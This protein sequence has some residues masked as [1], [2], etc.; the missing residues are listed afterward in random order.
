MDKKRVVISLLIIGLIFIAG[1]QSGYFDKQTVGS[2]ALEANW[3]GVAGDYNGDGCIDA[4]QYGDT[5]RGEEGAL[6]MKYYAGGNE[7][8]D[9]DANT[10]VNSDDFSIFAQFLQ[11]LACKKTKGLPDLVVASVRLDESFMQMNHFDPEDVVG[12]IVAVVNVGDAPARGVNNKVSNFDSSL[13][14][15]CNTRG[16]PELL[17]GEVVDV[18]VFCRRTG[19]AYGN[20]QIMPRSIF[21]GKGREMSVYLDDPDVNRESDEKNNMYTTTLRAFSTRGPVYSY[22]D[23][24]QGGLNIFFSS[25]PNCQGQFNSGVGKS[26]DEGCKTLGARYGEPRCTMAFELKEIKDPTTGA[27]IADKMRP[28]ECSSKSPTYTNLC[29]CCK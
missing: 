2:R 15:E 7:L 16:I 25:S 23:I 29:V 28:V 9:L 26:C 6:F 22:S 3:K 14:D 19:D 11:T 8:A 20:T 12:I 27:G 13:Y 10:Q 18:E 17:P 5:F 21:A 4:Y 24:G 1:C